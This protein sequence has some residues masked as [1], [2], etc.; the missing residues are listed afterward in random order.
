MSIVAKRS[1]ISAT[2]EL[3]LR[4]AHICVRIIVCNCRTQ[5]ST[6]P[7][8]LISFP[9]ILQTIIAAQMTSGVEGVNSYLLLSL[10]LHFNPHY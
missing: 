9:V 10:L 2:A 6:E 7:A 8:V 5:H 4:T 1:P 3:L